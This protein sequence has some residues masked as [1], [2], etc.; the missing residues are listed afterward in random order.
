MSLD[1]TTGLLN[2]PLGEVVRERGITMVGESG[3]FTIDDVNVLQEAGVGCLLV[4]ES[5]VKQD[6]P[7]VGIKKLYGR[8]LD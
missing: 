4:G 5:L 8:P 7:D 3:I 1:V 6:T 2:G